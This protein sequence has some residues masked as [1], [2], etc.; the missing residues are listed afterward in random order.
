[1]VLRRCFEEDG[2]QV[3]FDIG[4][5]EKHIPRQWN[6]LY[7]RARQGHSD[8]DDNEKPLISFL[9][10]R[11][12]YR[13]IENPFSELKT[14]CVWVAFKVDTWMKMKNAKKKCHI[15]KMRWNI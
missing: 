5:E 2:S 15:M 6:S 8:N 13:F 10:F 9:D 14:G 1:M 11:G 12:W 3:R 7:I 4:Y